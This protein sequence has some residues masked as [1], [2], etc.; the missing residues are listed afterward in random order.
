MAFVLKRMAFVL[1]RRRL[2]N[3]I[4]TEIKLAETMKQEIRESNNLL[5]KNIFKT[6]SKLMKSFGC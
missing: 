2:A 6:L 1:F 3:K 5:G 4:K